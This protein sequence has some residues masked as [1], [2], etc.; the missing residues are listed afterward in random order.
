MSKTE[1]TT[2]ELFYPVDKM[3]LQFKKNTEELN[4]L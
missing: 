1:A 4:N 2:Y 3:N